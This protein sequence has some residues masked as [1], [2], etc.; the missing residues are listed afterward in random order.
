[1]SSKDPVRVARARVALESRKVGDPARLHEARRVLTAAK[2]E[3]A[4]HEA[5]AATPPLTLDQR[6]TLAS[7]LLGGE[8]K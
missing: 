3:R 5:L 2:L 4:I 6:T 7:L 8:A 1:M